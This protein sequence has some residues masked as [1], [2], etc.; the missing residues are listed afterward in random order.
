MAGRTFAHGNIEHVEPGTET[1]GDKYIHSLFT[2][3]LIAAGW[4]TLLPNV[5]PEVQG[6]ALCQP[7]LP[8]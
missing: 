1:R 6:M 3:E 4:V 7:Y 5:T 2:Q 8:P